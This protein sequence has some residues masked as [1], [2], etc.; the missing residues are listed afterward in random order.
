MH[1]L[2]V[3]RRANAGAEGHKVSHKVGASK[4]SSPELVPALEATQGLENR[5]LECEQVTPEGERA[6]E[7]RRRTMWYFWNIEL[8]S[9]CTQSRSD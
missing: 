6:L 3:R 7:C 2:V 9:D 8:E 4:N 1:P 5:G